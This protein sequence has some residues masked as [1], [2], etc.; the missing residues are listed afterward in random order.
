MV[1]YRQNKEWI[2]AHALALAIYQNTEKFPDNAR[3]NLTDQLRN[4]S[5]SIPATIAE[6]LN[7]E[8]KADTIAFLKLA[9]HS[10]K[11]VEYYLLMSYELTYLN[12][13]EYECLKRNLVGL[14]EMMNQ[15]IQKSQH[16]A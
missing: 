3:N 15:K 16:Q 1:N 5:L 6:G 2:T 8:D 14:V 13:E 9:R 7:Q 11:E 12:A 10:I 4:V